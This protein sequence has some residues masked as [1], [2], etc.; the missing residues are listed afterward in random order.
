MRTHP[1]SGVVPQYPWPIPLLINQREM[2]G[3]N[4][5]ACHANV[6]GKHVVLYLLC[7]R[8]RDDEEEKE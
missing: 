5:P 2:A 6:T 7:W 4:V 3:A 8:N 1:Y